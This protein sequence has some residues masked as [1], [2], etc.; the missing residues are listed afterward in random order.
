MD[1][2][3][4]EPTRL[5]IDLLAPKHGERILDAGCGSGAAMKQLLRQVGCTVIGVDRSATMIA[6]ARRRLGGAAELHPTDIAEM[7]FADGTF[8]AILALNVLYF[9]DPR[10]RM[11]DSLR[12]VLRPGGRMVVYVTHRR[13]MASWSFAHKGVHRLFDEPSLAE[14]LIAGGFAAETIRVHSMSVTRSV[15]GLLALARR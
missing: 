14:A 7:P 1:V 4:R 9:C 2:A 6:A 12:R 3:N 15:S 11:I 10:H 8:D 13:S 5:A